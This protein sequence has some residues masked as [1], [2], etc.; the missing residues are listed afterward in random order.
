[1]Y[2]QPSSASAQSHSHDGPQ[3]SYLEMKRNRVVRNGIGAVHASKSV[4]QAVVL[5]CEGAHVSNLGIDIYNAMG[6]CTLG[7]KNVD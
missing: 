4:K 6:S 2:C 5:I 3:D 1:M 7:G